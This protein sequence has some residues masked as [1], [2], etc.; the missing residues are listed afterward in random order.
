M[1]RHMLDMAR[2]RHEPAQHVG[3]AQG[4]FRVR[5]HLHEVDIDVKEARVPHSGTFDLF[6]SGL[7]Y[8]GRFLGQGVRIRIA[9]LDIP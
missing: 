3:S 1:R 9:G 4:A 6:E 5:R 2:V 8:A 7:Q